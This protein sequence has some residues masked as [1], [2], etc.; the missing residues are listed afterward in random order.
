MRKNRGEDRKFQENYNTPLEHTPGN[1]LANY[2][3][4]PF[5]AGGK[6]GLGVCVPKVC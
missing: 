3:R 6:N 2:E 4:N 5:I 1:P